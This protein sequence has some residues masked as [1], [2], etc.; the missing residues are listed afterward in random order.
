MLIERSLGTVDSKKREGI[1]RQASAL[2]ARDVAF[3]PLHYQI[4]TWAMKD[5][6]S[7]VARTD[8]FTFAHHFKLRNP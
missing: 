3:I 7:Y 2:A 1:A 4:V 8:E 5:N 6:L